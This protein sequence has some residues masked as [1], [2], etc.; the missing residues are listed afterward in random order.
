MGDRIAGYAQKKEV[1]DE[2]ELILRSFAHDP[3]SGRCLITVTLIGFML[4][5]VAAAYDAVLEDLDKTLQVTVCI[6]V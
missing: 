4:A 1:R 6:Y 5:E 2:F 3:T